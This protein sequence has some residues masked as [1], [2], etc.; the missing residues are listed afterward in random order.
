M[1]TKMGLF[2]SPSCP[3]ILPPFQC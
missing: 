2:A 1:Q 3:R